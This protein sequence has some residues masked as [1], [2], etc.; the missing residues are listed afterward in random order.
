MPS[1]RSFIHTR[2]MG[3][4]RPL[5]VFLN[6]TRRTRPAASEWAM[7]EAAKLQEGN[8]AAIIDI[9]FGCP[10]RDVS[11][12]AES[13]SFLLGRPDRVGEIVSRVVAAC[14]TTPVTA[15]IIPWKF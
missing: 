10:A 5:P 8:G 7:A 6:A 14:G 12:K 15:K 11:Q 1:G 9:N 3:T 13:G 2:W 4:T